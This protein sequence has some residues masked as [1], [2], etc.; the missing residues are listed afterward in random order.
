MSN[1]AQ[2]I[3][4]V[5]VAFVFLY[6]PVAALST[7]DSWIGYFPPFLLHSGVPQAVLLHGFGIVEVVV[8]LWILSGYN[9]AWPA[10]LATLMLVAIVVFNLAQFEVIFRDLGLAGASLALAVDA[11][12]KEKALV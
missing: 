11:W 10:L 1:A 4:R 7:P 3:L 5:G 2:L 8:A 12:Y 9:I 6:P